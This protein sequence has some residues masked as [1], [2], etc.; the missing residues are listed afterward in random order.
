LQTEVSIKWNGKGGEVVIAY[1]GLEKL[2]MIL[3]KLTMVTP[4]EE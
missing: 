2:D 3:Q 1:D 4:S